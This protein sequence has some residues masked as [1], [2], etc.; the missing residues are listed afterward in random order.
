MLNQAR[1]NIKIIILIQALKFIG[2]EQIW[3]GGLIVPKDNPTPHFWSFCGRVWGVAPNFDLNNTIPPWNETNLFRRVSRIPCYLWTKVRPVI[4]RIFG[5]DYFGLNV[6]CVISFLRPPES[7]LVCKYRILILMSSLAQC[8]APP[9]NGPKSIGIGNNQ[10]KKMG[11]KH[12][13]WKKDRPQ[14]SSPKISIKYFPGVRPGHTSMGGALWRLDPKTHN[15]IRLSCVWRSGG[16]WGPNPNT[17]R[18][19]LR[20]GVFWRLDP[21]TSNTI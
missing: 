10:T 17:I 18:F 11:E 5:V 13:D 8:Q 16:F 21:K 2:Q 6:F 19:V 20:G 7:S 12:G 15:T 9:Q 14:E 3:K 1:N 4:Y